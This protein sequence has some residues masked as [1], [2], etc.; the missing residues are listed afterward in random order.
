[1]NLINEIITVTLL[2]VV[3]NIM[4]IIIKNNVEK[5][6]EKI[7]DEE[8]KSKTIEKINKIKNILILVLGIVCF[9]TLIDIYNILIKDTNSYIHMF[10]IVV[11]AKINVVHLNSMF[12]F[13]VGQ[14]CLYLEMLLLLITNK[15]MIKSIVTTV[16]VITYI[17]LCV[18]RLYEPY[19]FYKNSKKYEYI[20]E[21]NITKDFEE[22]NEISKEGAIK[23]VKEQFEVEYINNVN[24]ELVDIN[25]IEDTNIKYSCEFEKFWI[26]TF[27][28]MRNYEIKE[29]ACVY[30]DLYTGKLAY[31]TY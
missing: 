30:V 22:D 3:I 29:N 17:A 6:V 8:K 31:L 23:I 21:I 14:F 27:D 19:N 18:Y 28:Y 24:A 26:I 25:E 9:A 20:N 7:E 13:A 2:L 4:F 16:M 1:M 15:K 5:K 11:F 12:I 10:G